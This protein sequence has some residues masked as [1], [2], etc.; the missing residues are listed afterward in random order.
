MKLSE[1]FE[2]FSLDAPEESEAVSFVFM[3]AE[4]L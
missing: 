1:D 4:E 3:D 2:A